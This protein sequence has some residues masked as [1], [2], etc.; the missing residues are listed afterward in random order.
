MGLAIAFLNI[1]AFSLFVYSFPVQMLPVVYLSIAVM[2]VICNIGYE[3]IEHKLTP[4]QLLK[5]IIG[6]CAFLLVIIWIGLSFGNKQ[7]FIFILLMCNTLVYMIASFAFWGLVSLLFNV[8]E[9]RRV[10]SVVGAGD[11]P[12]KLIGYLVAPLLI[13]LFGLVHLIW[14]AVFFLLVSLFVFQRV[15][16]KKS[17]ET[18]RK[19]A[20][21]HATEHLEVAALKQTDLV[22]FFFKDKLIFIIS[23]LSIL[24][25]N[26]FVLVDYTFISQVKMRFANI[27][28]LAIYVAAFFAIG[29]L[30]AA[31]FKLLFTS[32]LIERLGIINCL[33]ITPVVL[34][35]ACILFLWYGDDS[36]T[37][38]YIFGAM[39]MLTEVLR[40]TMQEPVFFILFQPLKE[41]LRLKGHIIS[42][43]YMLPP[44]LIIVGLTLLF[45][46]NSGTPITILF[47]IKIILLN[48]VVWAVIIVFV[49]RSYLQTL[50]A[51]IR[52]GIL[53][54][55]KSPASG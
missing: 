47:T 13:A 46:Y 23:L 10:F 53:D 26:V 50:H 5:F 20:H 14:V 4:P 55:P 33:F 12:A 8:R 6:L 29:R 52:K 51:S 49:Q 11:I 18:I 27:A 34:L 43:G 35:M 1:V 25:Y 16:R 9:S 2:M 42:K 54:S 17:W 48:L 24:S 44:S 37:N 30:V 41:Q 36:H 7:D 28:D 22:N 32:Q 40:S 39:A 38:I 19:K 3:K 21:A 31:V 45:L 15:I